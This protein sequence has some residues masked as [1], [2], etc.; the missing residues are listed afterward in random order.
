MEAHGGRGG[1][2]AAARRAAAVR[3]FHEARAALD[4]T[5]MAE[6]ALRLPAA[7]EFGEHPGQL[8]ALVHEAY[9][10]VQ[11]ADREPA[12]QARLAAALARTWVYGGDAARAE[13][14]AREALAIA[15]GLGDRVSDQEVLADALD[16]ALLTRWGPDDLAVR[17]ELTAR[18]SEAAAHLTASEPR[19]SALLWRLTTAWECLDLVTVHRQLRA[20]DTSPTT[21][22]TRGSRSSPRRGLR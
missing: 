6:A 13:V 12:L 7:L 14:F 22:P 2:Q 9:I 1:A 10:A 11:Q 3:A 20:L 8:P 17:V 15:T 19:L 5:A 21:P 16:A 18:L 4:V